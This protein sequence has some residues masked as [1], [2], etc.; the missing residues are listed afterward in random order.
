MTWAAFERSSYQAARSWG[1]QPSEFWKLPVYDFWAEL[2]AKV[3]EAE[4]LR[5]MTAG[6]KT[7]G[8]VFSREDWEAA[9]AKHRE[10]KGK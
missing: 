6:Q 8:N 2:D 7:S 4:K 5:E 9:R 3:I 1:I 10:K